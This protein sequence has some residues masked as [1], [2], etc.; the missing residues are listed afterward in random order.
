MTNELTYTQIGDYLFPNIRLDTKEP[1]PLTKYGWMRRT[2][3]QEN[4]PTLFSILTMN[5]KLYDHLLEVQQTAERRIEQI[6]SEL[7][8]LNPAPNK[9]RQRTSPQK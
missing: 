2:F 1:I 9:E 7:L 6:T 4:N 5:L 3:L 8:T